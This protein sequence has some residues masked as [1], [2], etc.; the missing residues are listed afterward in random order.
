VEPSGGTIVALPLTEHRSASPAPPAPAPLETSDG[1]PEAEAVSGT[2]PLAM[3]FAELRARLI[4]LSADVATLRLLCETRPLTLD[5]AS[6]L[7]QLREESDRLH[8]RLAELRDSA[9]RN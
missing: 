4:W 3:E 6:R 8:T 2:L 9:L 5:E 7:A 1:V